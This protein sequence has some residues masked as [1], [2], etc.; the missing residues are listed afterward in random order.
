[1]N[2]NEGEIDVDNDFEVR[3]YNDPA[4]DR[5]SSRFLKRRTNKKSTNFINLTI[6]NVPGGEQTI[7]VL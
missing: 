5:S 6:K 3:P 1:M 7:I 2:T 4:F